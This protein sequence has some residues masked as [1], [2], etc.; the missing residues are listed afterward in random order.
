MRQRGHLR[1]GAGAPAGTQGAAAL[2]ATTRCVEG[3]SWYCQD[4]ATAM[5][6]S[7]LACA[8]Q[9]ML[10]RA[11][12]FNPAGCSIGRQL[13]KYAS[14]WQHVLQRISQARPCRC[15]SP[16]ANRLNSLQHHSVACACLHRF[17][18]CLVLVA[19]TA[20]RSCSSDRAAQARI[21][22]QFAAADATRDGVA[23]ECHQARPVNSG[24]PAA[25]VQ[26]W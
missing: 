5:P 21:D 17:A 3:P 11:R 12:I 19:C 25:S 2:H 1:P 18:W 16:F 23:A 26:T 14:A 7:P 24:F 20:Q 6:G 22:L 4:P 15:W 10:P 13:H 8:L 9:H